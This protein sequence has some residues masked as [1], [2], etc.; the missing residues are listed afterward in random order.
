MDGYL[1][2]LHHTMDDLPVRLFPRT[3]QGETMALLFLGRLQ[4]MPK[5]KIRKIYSTDCS[6]PVCGTIVEFVAG[7]PIRI[8]DGRISFEDE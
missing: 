5:K 8:L 4:P 3:P 6:T 7:K 1:V 2:M